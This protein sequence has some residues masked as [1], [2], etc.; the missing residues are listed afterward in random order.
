M[1]LL[2]REIS[3]ID[4]SNLDIKLISA[5]LYTGASGDILEQHVT[6]SGTLIIPLAGSGKL[7]RA[8]GGTLLE[9]EHIY[10]CP[11]E[12][13]FGLT[14]DTDGN[15]TVVVIR[16]NVAF[17]NDRVLDSQSNESTHFLFT[18]MEGLS[19]APAGN[20]ASLGRTI[21]DGFVSGDQLKKWRA[22][23][24]CSE[25]LY[26]LITSG[27]KVS[28]EGSKEALER[29]KAFMKENSHT[30]MTI[31]RLANM[32]E[33]SPKYFVD[34]F[35]KTYGVSALDYLTKIRID[36]AKSL[37]LR[38]DRLLKEIAHEV[39]YADEFYFSRKFKQIVGMSPTAYLKKRGKRLRYMV[40]QL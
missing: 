30:E 34:L 10:T 37:M 7:K 15:L 28:K 18:N 26:L 29:T 8:D 19:L 3:D 32:A 24:D 13:T 5:E 40:L 6:R 25:L 2:N 20:L 21:Y 11:P 12:S 9:R 16:L 1:E 31:E 27:K 14:S 39:G 23:L 17:W 33:L 4:Y 38:T 36:R 22:Q 35:K